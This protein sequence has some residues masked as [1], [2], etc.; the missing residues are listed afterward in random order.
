MKAYVE[1]IPLGAIESPIVPILNNWVYVESEEKPTLPEGINVE[2]ESIE[3]GLWRTKFTCSIIQ[4]NTIIK[5]LGETQ[6]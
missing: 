3:P 5:L 1:S 4:A 6:K 2:L